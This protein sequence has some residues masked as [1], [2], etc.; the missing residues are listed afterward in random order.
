M[1]VGSPTA[2]TV[3]TQT[4]E[5][6]PAPCEG[7]P[8]GDADQGWLKLEAAPTDAEAAMPVLRS[9]GQDRVHA[10]AV[11]ADALSSGVEEILR[12]VPSNASVRSKAAVNRILTKIGSHRQP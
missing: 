9:L 11:H 10:E 4:K 7:P 1:E 6:S 5:Q 8:M 12:A 2:S 3:A